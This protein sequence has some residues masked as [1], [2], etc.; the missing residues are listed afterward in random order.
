MVDVLLAKFIP[1]DLAVL[2]HELNSL[3]LGDIGH[4]VAGNSYN[5]S[6]LFRLER[7]DAVLPAQHFCGIAS[8]RSNYVKRRHAGIAQ[9][10]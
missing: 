9:V 7:S 8:D 2:H 10:N 6:K 5:V 4:G 1:N 3:E